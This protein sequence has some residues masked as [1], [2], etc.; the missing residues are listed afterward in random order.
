MPI[1]ISPHLGDDLKE[2]A[3]S[4]TFIGTS[5]SAE[6]R[7]LTSLPPLSMPPV[8]LLGPED[9][10]LSEEILELCDHLAYLPM[11]RGVNSLNVASASAIFLHHFQQAVIRPSA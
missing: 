11:T 9:F 6:S 7:P 3:K 1:R 5:L 4:R 2:L 10:G 8:L